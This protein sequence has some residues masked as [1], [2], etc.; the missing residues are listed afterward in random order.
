MHLFRHDKGRRNKV[1]ETKTAF[2]N[3][4]QALLLSETRIFHNT[5]NMLLPHT[6]QLQHKMDLKDHRHRGPDP[7][8]YIEILVPR[9]PPVAKCSSPEWFSKSL[10]GRSSSAAF[11]ALAALPFDVRLFHKLRKVRTRHW[12]MRTEASRQMSLQVDVETEELKVNST[13]RAHA[14]MLA[15]PTYSTEGFFS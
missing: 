3:V 1:W 4:V 15:T 7:W 8:L 14:A 9:W 13:L 6:A 12:P 10:Y 5:F 11:A 2:H